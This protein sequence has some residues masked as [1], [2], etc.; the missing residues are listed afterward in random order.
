VYPGKLN[1][2]S[3]KLT[4]RKGSLIAPP[5]ELPVYVTDEIVIR[6]ERIKEEIFR[7]PKGVVVLDRRDIKYSGARN[8]LELLNQVSGV[9]IVDRTGSGVDGMVSIRGMDPA[10]YTIVMVDGIVVNR[11]DGGVSWETI[12][13]TLVKRIEII[14]GQPSTPIGGRAGGGIINI[15]TEEKGLN[16]ITLSSTNGKDIGWNSVIYG[17]KRWNLWLNTTGRKGVGWREGERYDIKGVY[18][19]FTF[20]IKESR[21][22]IFSINGESQEIILPKGLTE[23]ELQEN[24]KQKG[25]D[26]EEKEISSFRFTTTY[27]SQLKRGESFKIITTFMPEKYKIRKKELK[28]KEKGWKLSGMEASMKGEYRRKNMEFCSEVVG[29]VGKR[30]EIWEEGIIK[31]TENSYEIIWNNFLEW[32]RELFNWITFRS[33]VSYQ[34]IGYW[35]REFMGNKS[36]EFIEN[37]LTPRI[38]ILVPFRIGE[39]FLSLEQKILPPKVYEKARN[40]YLVPEITTSFECGG[41][42]KIWIFNFGGA[43][44]LNYIENEIFTKGFEFENSREGIIHRGVEGEVTFRM[45]K[46]L[47]FFATYTYIKAQFEH[48]KKKVPEIR[49]YDGSVGVRFTYLP[50]YSIVISY[51]YYGKAYVDKKYPEVFLSPYKRLDFCFKFRPFT[52]FSINLLCN[53]FTEEK[54]KKFGY[55][56]EGTPYYYPLEPCGYKIE[57]NLEF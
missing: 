47:S 28:N 23:K 32:K 39:L 18:G 7:I 48:S 14:K 38:G 1:S 22:L 33:G 21:K 50:T 19:K 26:E 13:L 5:D 2:V 10:K 30:E 6:G 46:L 16:K 49:E 11:L 37:R 53:N 36:S 54:G 15:I 51:N 17:E 29:I 55:I 8:L 42:G 27:S 3:V 24:P 57:V 41:R 31:K 4:P 56:K 40:L 45:G 20:P 52:N 35:V 34:L 44:F 12:P 43:G 9:S 25:K